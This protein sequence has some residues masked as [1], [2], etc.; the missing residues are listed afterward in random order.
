LRALGGQF[1]PPGPAGAPARG[2][3]DVL[4]TG[5]NLYAIDPRAI[6]TRAAMVLATRA[7]DA[8]LQRH[9]EDHGEWPRR[10]VLDLWGSSTLRTGGEDLALALILMGAEPVWDGGSNRITGVEIT[11]LARLGRPRV[12]V[13][14]HVSG[15][16]RDAFETQMALFDIAVRAIAARDEPDED[17]PLAATARGLGD[18]ALRA[19]TARIYGPAPGAYGG[20]VAER[21]RRDLHADRESLGRS[22][23]AG[24]AYAYGQGLDGRADPQGFAARVAGA[25][26][27]LHLQ[28]HAEIDLLDEA[29][30][31]ASE[32]GFAAAAD[33]LGSAP[34]LYHADT[35]RPETPRL[36]TLAEE[37][38]RVA[39]GRA[40]NPA[41]IAG[42]MRHGYRGAAEIGRSL[43]ALYGFAALVPTRFDRQFDLVFDATLGAA[44][45]DAFLREANPHARAAMIARFRAARERDLWR[46]RRNSVAELLDAP[47]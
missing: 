39:R 31:A 40:A 44:E 17:N 42:M 9:L 30:F 23:L 28:D 34:A 15:L 36:R 35:S 24:A 32:G 13:T 14:L 12:D 7:A 8:L 37:V 29:E 47:P 4:P 26:A 38:A 5:R 1:V 16:F 43:E 3:L 25:Q 10:L 20:D 33:A 22:Y 45:V 11:P 6:P 18:A 2:R 27:M 19:A 41:W 46:P 21:L